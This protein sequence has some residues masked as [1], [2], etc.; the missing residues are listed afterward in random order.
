MNLCLTCIHKDGSGYCQYFEAKMVL[1]A[2][3]CRGYE[4]KGVVW[5]LTN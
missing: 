3:Y 4:T 2:K 5:I 1:E